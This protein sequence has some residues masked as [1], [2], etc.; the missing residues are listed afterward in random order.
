MVALATDATLGLTN[1]DEEVVIDELE[2]EGELPAW[3][4]G[5]LLR[6][7]PARWDLG[8]QSVNHWFDGLAMLHRFTV[9]GGSV[10]YANRFLRTKAFAAAQ[11]GRLGFR[12]FATDPCRSAFQR[13][14]SLF[15]PG[16]TD[17]A[18]VNVAKVMGR[19]VALTETPLAVQFDPETLQTLGVQEIPANTGGLAHPHGTSD[20]RA[21]SM[22]VHMTGPRPA[23]RLIEDDRVLARLP[24]R[25][26]AYIHSFALT[27]RHAVLIEHPY[28]VN[29]LKLGFGNRPFIENFRW[30]PDHGTRL[31]VFDRSSGEHIGDWHTDPF[32]VF[33]NVNAFED[34][35]DIVIDL[36]AYDDAAIVA[37]LGLQRLRA[38]E[39]IPP[40]HLDR[41]RLRPGGAVER[42]RLSDVPF[43]LPRI[44]YGRVNGG[45]YRYA[46]GTTVRREF[47]DAIVKVDVTTGETLPWGEGYPGEPVYVGR[48]GREAE[49]D[50]VLLT[51]V[52]EPD[53][54]TSS[55]VVLDAA[56]L[57]ELARARVPHHVPFGFHGQ[58]SRA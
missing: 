16:F 51:V 31:V 32:F 1:L 34:G 39:P 10:S 8:E 54:G 20:G 46:W 52:L 21:L 17:N 12:E 26:P 28:T 7:G 29:P 55:M 43:E 25:R 33:H 19:W 40:S 45:P 57:T 5:S 11:D 47:F 30:Q 22:G 50:G 23:Y 58:F 14:A 13:V 35:G 3:L 42:T 48:P 41:F 24:V 53:R 56:T 18:N 44:D 37:A 15:E 6:T 49:D 9:A 4:G 38:G 2:L 36:C 27:D